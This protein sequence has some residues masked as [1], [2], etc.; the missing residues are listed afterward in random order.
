[1]G[2]IHS[3]SQMKAPPLLMRPDASASSSSGT[4]SY[5]PIPHLQSGIQHLI[6]SFGVVDC[7]R[8]PRIHP[9]QARCAGCTQPALATWPGQCYLKDEWQRSSDM[10]S[11]K[12]PA[13]L[14]PRRSSGT[15]P[16]SPLLSDPLRSRLSTLSFGTWC[17]RLS[18]GGSYIR[19]GC[20][21]RSRHGSITMRPS[22]PTHP[23]LDGRM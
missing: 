7:Q 13:L 20:R 10:P 15:C 16:C 6:L 2:H 9:L 4:R 17:C 8:Y 18:K 14:P 3:E 19:E 5:R 22:P 1:M 12:T 11:V 21:S 23:C